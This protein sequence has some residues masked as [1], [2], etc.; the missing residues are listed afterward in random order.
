MPTP[1]VLSPKECQGKTW[2]PPH[3]LNFAAKKALIPLHAGEIAKAAATMPLALIKENRECLTVIL[4]CWVLRR[5]S[6]F[7]MSKAK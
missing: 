1:L 2:Y 7:S 5:V 3:D 6:R 4:A